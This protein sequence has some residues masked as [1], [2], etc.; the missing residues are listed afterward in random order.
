MWGAGLPVAIASQLRTIVFGHDQQD[1]GPGPVIATLHPRG[2]G[3]VRSREKDKQDY[4]QYQALRH[5]RW[6]VSVQARPRCNVENKKFH[7]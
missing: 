2:I 3:H 6:L 5:V 7:L 4:D 1:I